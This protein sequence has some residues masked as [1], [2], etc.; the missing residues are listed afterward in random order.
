M[1]KNVALI[2]SFLLLS[3]T[4]LPLAHAEN[5]AMENA[6]TENAVTENAV[7]ENKD[8]EKAITEKPAQEAKAAKTS[9]DYNDLKVLPQDL[10]DK[11][12][13]FIR[14]DTF[15]AESEDS[16][17]TNK[18]ITRDEFVKAAKV[19]FSLPSDK[20]LTNSSY[21]EE[22]GKLGLILPEGSVVEPDG[23]IKRQDLA[24]YLIAGLG[25]VND[26]RKV[27][28]ITDSSAAN[29]DRVDKALSR[30]VTLALQ[31]K[32]MKNQED[33]RFFGDRV[34]TRKMLVEAAYETKKVFTEKNDSSKVSIKEAKAVGAKKVSVIFDTI[35]D[36]AKAERTVLALKRDGNI[37]NGTIEWSEDKKSATIVID[38]KLRKGNYSVELSGLDDASVEKKTAEFT[39]ED[40]QFKTLE[41]VNSSDNLTRSKG[42]T[43]ELKHKNQYGEQTELSANRFDIRVGS[44]YNPVN[45]PDKQAFKLDLSQANRDDRIPITVLDIDH[46]LS[47]TKVFTV[48]DKVQISKIDMGKLAYKDNKQSLQPGNKAYLSFI[49]YDQ[50]GNRVTD[51]EELQRGIKRISV[52]E[53]IFIDNGQNVF[54]DYDNDGNVEIE[55]EAMTNIYKDSATTIHLIA[56]GSGES[57]TKKISVSTPKKPASVEITE[58]KTTLADED[59]NVLI[60]LVVRD[61]EGYEFSAQEKADLASAGKI[62]VT[63]TGGISLGSPVT[64][65]TGP[66]ILTG[67][68]AGSIGIKE[69][70]GTGPATIEV[71][72]TDINKRTAANY[73]IM[74]K[75]I[76]TALEKSGFEPDQLYTVIQT[77]SVS[78]AFIIKDQYDE[79]YKGITND[80]YQV[81]YKLEKI[82]G[83][84]GAFAGT[85]TDAKPTLRFT[86][87]DSSGKSI[88]LL[89]VDKKIGS[90][91]MTATLVKAVKDPNNLLNPT[92]WPIESKL[93]SLAARAQSYTWKE[94]DKDDLTYVLD[95]E[96]NLFAVGKYLVDRGQKVKKND[97]DKNPKANEADAAEI[98]KNRG[99]LAKPLNII[100][101][102]KDGAT[103]TTPAAIIIRSVGIS[104]TSVIAVDNANLP[105]KIVGLNPGTAVANIVFDTPSGAKSIKINFTTFASDLNFKRLEV[106]KKD[107]TILNANTNEIDGRY[108][109]D[110]KLIQKITVVDDSDNT[111]FNSVNSAGTNSEGLTPFL[112]TFGVTMKLTDVTYK[113]GTKDA[114]KD[115]FSM[116]DDYKLVF[117]PKSGK[118]TFSN[119]NLKSFTI[120]MI[121]PD[122]KPITS[123]FILK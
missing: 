97:N 100:A 19:I 74:K 94:L 118:Y 41:F 17:G 42:T 122:N 65:E 80:E 14:E 96:Q 28:P 40:E 79:E 120:T 13:Y 25:L 32:V 77:R 71:R 47:I 73:T 45:V 83:D 11:F 20:T 115:T 50:Y 58:F 52:G 30:Y 67:A 51:L 18:P 66:I 107:P 4:V 112:G 70:K 34:V 7:V 33:G 69:I 27:E 12:D 26:V 81:E 29:E 106:T 55:L 88:T 31:L 89:A 37:I 60:G 108:I 93:N 53:N 8:T 61:A 95:A 57:V 64:G 104:D 75:R 99:D 2:S 110:I 105:K 16:F 54:F 46:N 44:G 5:A 35:V 111:F 98:F 68:S 15:A 84:A 113:P 72:M 56:L 91:K 49:A 87:K 48:G 10:K 92:Q 76:P 43:I 82:S 24:R 85:L 109:W 21:L 23:S 59:V 1:K 101:K 102:N 22:F 6:V 39:A 119:V 63:S 114:D 3:M 90:Y 38:E 123:T 121:G 103:V 36:S 117:K 86:V 116:T 78:P 62:E 9:E